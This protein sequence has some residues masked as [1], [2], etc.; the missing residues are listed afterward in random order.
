MFCSKCGNQ[1]P[2]GSGFCHK[3]GAKLVTSESAQQ[4]PGVPASMPANAPT[5]PANGN[6]FREFVDNHVR[7]VTRYKTA[8]D[9]MKKS[10][11][12]LFVWI[13]MGVAALLVLPRYKDFA[14]ASLNPISDTTAILLCLL[15]TAVMGYIVAYLAGRIL[16]FIRWQ[17]TSK[18]KPAYPIPEEVNL[19]AL[20]EFLS[21]NLQ[22]LSPA[23]DDWGCAVLK[24]QPTVKCS[25]QGKKTNALIAFVT[26]SAGKKFYAFSA[27]KAKV[28]SYLV[29][30]PAGLSASK[31]NAGFGEYRCLYRAAPILTA[32]VGFYLKGL[33][34]EILT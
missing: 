29:I 32:A 15:I 28:W 34:N 14:N 30:S 22:Y 33:G 4:A 9:L 2:E 25:F 17:K 13:C 21:T 31:T 1:L 11:P 16:Y 12:M 8:E 19:N 5:A 3:C 27:Q 26:T 20:V 6:G 18:A 10:K 7:S 23:F 24:G